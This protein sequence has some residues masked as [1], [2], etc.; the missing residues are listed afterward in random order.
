[1]W[2]EVDTLNLSH[3]ELLWEIMCSVVQPKATWCRIR[4]TYWSLI[5]ARCFF[6][7][8]Q[9]HIFIC[10]LTWDIPATGYII[11][12]VIGGWEECMIWGV[13]IRRR[14][15][16]AEHVAF[17]RRMRNSCNSSVGNPEW[18]SPLGGIIVDEIIKLRWILTTPEQ[19]SVD[20]TVFI[21]LRTGERV[22]RLIP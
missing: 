6:A 5:F 17:M 22:R 16:W 9:D 1:M 2:P 4:R 11:E 18:K 21:R 14:F 19:V 10:W 8:F 15:E 3:F 12:K 13:M 7:T 20:C